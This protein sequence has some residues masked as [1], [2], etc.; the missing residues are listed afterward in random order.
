MPDL[1]HELLLR[2]AEVAP[3][4]EALSYQ[5]TRLDY[6]ALATL[7]VDCAAGLLHL[8]LGRSERVAV[9][10]EKRP[11]TVAAIFGAAAAGGGFVALNPLA[12]PDQ[13]PG[14]LAGC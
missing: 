1:I 4:R 14:H 13:R 11:E 2:S 9:Y 7:V 3:Q 10:L 8:G 5:S 6:D 12:E